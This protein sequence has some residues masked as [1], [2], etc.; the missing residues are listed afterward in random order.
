[1]A[2][3]HISVGIGLRRLEVIHLGVVSPSLEVETEVHAGQVM[4]H[5]VAEVEGS[6]QWLKISH[7]E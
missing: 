1:M 2:T 3:L 7:M 4:V 5:K 6:L